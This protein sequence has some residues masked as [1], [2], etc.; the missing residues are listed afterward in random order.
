MGNACFIKIDQP[1]TPETPTL[2]N[3]ATHYEW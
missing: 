3:S 2:L 1:P